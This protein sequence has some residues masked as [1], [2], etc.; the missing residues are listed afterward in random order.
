MAFEMQTAY[1]QDSSESLNPSRMFL[2]VI[3]LGEGAR[4]VLR[5]GICW[6]VLSVFKHSFYIES[7]RGDLVCLGPLSMGAGPLNALYRFTLKINWLD[8]GLREDAVVSVNGCVLQISDRF[9]FDLAGAQ[10]WQPP[11]TINYRSL[12][13]ITAGLSLINKFALYHA[14][15]ESLGYLIPGLIGGSATRNLGTASFTAF[16]QASL[17]GVARLKSWLGDRLGGGFDRV[18]PSEIR[19][20]LGLGPGLT[21]SGDDLLGGAFIALHSLGRGEIAHQLWNW[22]RLAARARTNKIS[23]SHM[24]WAARGSGAAPIHMLMQAL[25]LNNR[26]ELSDRIKAVDRIGHTS[27]WDALAGIALVCLSFIED[28]N[29]CRG[30]RVRI[31]GDVRCH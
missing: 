28:H 15:H 18:P 20:L 7:S 4:Q 1:R 21:P 24:D 17:S 16:Q 25:I 23:L 8:R 22:L 19:S 2:P 29:L 27:G 26:A 5:A 10:S 30:N 9:L 31:S 11:A 6:R 14:P 3:D 12:K 13:A